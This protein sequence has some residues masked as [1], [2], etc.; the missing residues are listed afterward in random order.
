MYKIVKGILEKNN[1]K[2][3]TLGESYYPSFHPFKYP[4]PPEGDRI[5]EMK[6]DFKMMKE[7]G[8]NHIRIAAIGTAKLS[9]DGSFIIDTPFVDAMI[10]EAEKLQLS[11]SVRLQGYS[12][13]LREFKNVCMIDADGK[14]QD[15]SM[16]FD[17]IQTTLCHDGIL[18][19]NRTLSDKLAS[20]YSKKKSVVGFQIY[21]EP[22]FPGMVFFDYHPE[23]IKAYR[24]WLVTHGIMTMSESENY[25]PPRSRKEQSPRMWALWRLFSQQSLSDFLDNASVPAKS[26][27]NLPTFTCLT[28]CTSIPASPYRGADMFANARTSMDIVGYTC[29]F[30]AV[31]EEY[32]SMNLFLDI[33]SCAAASEG[34]ETWCVELDSR[35]TIPCDIFNKN[36][37]AV[38]GSGAK[39]IIYY[40]WRG[41]HPSEATPIPNGCGLVNYD[42]SKTNNFDNAAKMISFIN[43]M[44]DY[45]VNTKRANDGIGVFHSD[46][47]IFMCDATENTTEQRRDN[48]LSNS[49]LMQYKEVYSELRKKNYTVHILDAV[50]LKNNCFGIHTLFVPR[51][52]FLSDEEKNIIN[53]FIENGGTVFESPII[54]PDTICTNRGYMPYGTE[55]DNYNTFYTIHELC[56]EFLEAPSVNCDNPLIGVQELCGDNY[57]LILL[58]NLSCKR[59]KQSLK[60]T[61]TAMVREAVLCSPG[62]KIKLKTSHNEIFA[63]EL[64]DGGIII[65]KH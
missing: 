8:F 7:M 29:Y 64:D 26:S 49:Y 43:E 23:A 19:D 47:A 28:T 14:P 32:Y 63:D 52:D 33:A 45:I 65:V 41:D 4:V 54:I 10:D 44:S 53:E 40:Q 11:I 16:W 60:L 36:S 6:K 24:K 22:H 48:S 20:Y 61:C 58:T 50:A 3:F 9:E 38:I 55:T 39:G 25:N 21:N 46:Y 1:K 37:Y 5:G 62:K 17:F 2:I 57:S 31:G 15:T 42:G 30:H 27:G 35:T 18:E 56:N 59:K 12:V 51:R 34:K 13:N